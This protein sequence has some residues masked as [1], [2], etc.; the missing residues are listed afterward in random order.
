MAKMFFLVENGSGDDRGCSI[1]IGPEDANLKKL[2]KEFRSV[3]NRPSPK[4]KL[5]AAETWDTGSFATWLVKNKGF[6]QPDNAKVF[7]VDEYKQDEHV[8]EFKAIRN[9]PNTPKSLDEV[10]AKIEAIKKAMK[11]P[12]VKPA[13]SPSLMTKG[14]LVYDEGTVPEACCHIQ[15]P[16]DRLRGHADALEI[17][18]D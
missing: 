4:H 11:N 6:S 18:T 8:Q 14:W 13:D 9:D 3:D 16:L 2:H 1:V 17:Q 12:R 5:H 15:I 10:K 7:Y